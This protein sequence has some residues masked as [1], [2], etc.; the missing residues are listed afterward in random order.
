[1]LKYDKKIYVVRSNHDEH[2]DKWINKG[3]TNVD[4][5]NLE[6]FADIIA[7]MIKNKK[8]DGALELYVKNELVKLKRKD[9]LRDL[10]FINRRQPVKINCWAYS[11]SYEIQQCCICWVYL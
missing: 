6:H 11:C 5:N 4:L 8:I 3:F 9:V 7:Q 10:V 2:L 1:M